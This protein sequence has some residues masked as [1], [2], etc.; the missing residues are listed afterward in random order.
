[1]VVLQV[2]S[3]RG[4]GLESTRGKTRR[5]GLVQGEKNKTKFKE[6]EREEGEKGLRIALELHWHFHYII[7]LCCNLGGA[8][9]VLLHALSDAL[10]PSAKQRLDVE[11]LTAVTG[12]HHGL[13]P[14]DSLGTY[15]RCKVAWA[16]LA[17]FARRSA[18]L[19]DS[20]GNSASRGRGTAKAA[21]GNPHR[22]ASRLLRV[23]GEARPQQGLLGNWT[24]GYG[25]RC[26]GHYQSRS[27]GLRQCLSQQHQ[28]RGSWESFGELP[29]SWTDPK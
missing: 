15:T 3:N 26:Y 16:E 18:G 25:F 2:L 22:D 7:F 1:M 5:A 23:R 10:T 13:K 24:T 19:A 11:P 20:L 8:R 21:Q 14:A 17:D 29:Q 28:A 9:G 12:E 27:S 4:K 6:G